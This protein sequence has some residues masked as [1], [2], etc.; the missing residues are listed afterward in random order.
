MLRRNPRVH[1]YITLI[2]LLTL[3]II[4]AVRGR[5]GI[6]L[7]SSGG[8]QRYYLRWQIW[9]GKIF[10]KINFLIDFSSFPIQDCLMRGWKN[11]SRFFLFF[12]TPFICKCCISF[13]GIDR[14]RTILSLVHKCITPM[15]FF[16]FFL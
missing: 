4:I 12:F 2:Y 10:R 1:L 15:Y 6:L 11:G 7:Y 16:F 13:K 3:L 8:V 14:Q 9:L 5:P